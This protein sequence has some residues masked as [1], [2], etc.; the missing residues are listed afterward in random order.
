MQVLLTVLLLRRAITIS[1]LPFVDIYTNRI[2]EL[3]RAGMFSLK[4]VPQGSRCTVNLVWRQK[5]EP[6]V[7]F[8]LLT[9]LQT[10]KALN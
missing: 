3:V 1:E 8:Y 10:T 2:L 4:S 9:M 5:C 7:Y 6:L